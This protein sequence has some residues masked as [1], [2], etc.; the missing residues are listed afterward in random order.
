MSARTVIL[1][2]VPSVFG[3]VLA[4]S[5]WIYA[6]LRETEEEVLGEGKLRL[7]SFSL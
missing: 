3:M 5:T 6:M 1:I 2:V 4:I 7:V